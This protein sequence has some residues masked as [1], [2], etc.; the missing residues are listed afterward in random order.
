LQ[1]EKKKNDGKCLYYINNGFQAGIAKMHP[2]ISVWKRCFAECWRYKRR[3]TENDFEE[4]HKGAFFRMSRLVSKE[5]TFNQRFYSKADGFFGSFD[6]GIEEE[7][8]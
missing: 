7:W 8:V 5:F 2:L 6:E 1:D 3:F 4:N